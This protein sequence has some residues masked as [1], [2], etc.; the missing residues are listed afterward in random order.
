MRH[1][2]AGCGAERGRVR[3][4][5]LKHFPLLSFLS[6]KPMNNKALRLREVNRVFRRA[7]LILGFVSFWEALRL[8]VRYRRRY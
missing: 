4:L 6:I 5:V 7:L 3:H 1:Y 2:D 8:P